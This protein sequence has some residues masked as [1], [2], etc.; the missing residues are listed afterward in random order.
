ME[1]TLAAITIWLSLVSQKGRFFAIKNLKYRANGHHVD[2]C[3]QTYGEA[4]NFILPFL[5]SCVLKCQS[6]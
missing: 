5:W 1:Y 4:N 6:T 2:H 3:F